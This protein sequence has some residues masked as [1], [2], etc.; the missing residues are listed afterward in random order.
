LDLNKISFTDMLRLTEAQKKH[1]ST[2]TERKEDQALELYRNDH[3]YNS[4]GL[5]EISTRYGSIKMQ[6]KVPT[7]NEYAS[8]GF[9]WV[10]GI[11]NTIQQ[12]FGSTVQGE[13]RNALILDRA[14]MLSMGEYS[15]WVKEIGF[16]DG[17]VISDLDTIRNTLAEISGDPELSADFFT[18]VLAFIEECTLSLIALPRFNCPECGTPSVPP[19]MAKHPYLN[20]IDV[21]ALFFT[22]QGQHIAKGLS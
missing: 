17:H 9:E 6:L 3:S 22:M 12:A 13:A 1:M 20:P 16:K 21:E 11:A 5:I 8:A 7:I 14:K 10:D 15:H 18:K 19:E 2:R 4:K